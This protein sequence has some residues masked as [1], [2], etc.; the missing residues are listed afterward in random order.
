MDIDKIALGYEWSPRTVEL[1]HAD[2]EQYT[3]GGEQ[4]LKNDG[5]QIIMGG[6]SHPDATWRLWNTAG[7]DLGIRSP[8]LAGMTNMYIISDSELNSNALVDDQLL[9]PEID[10]TNYVK[11]LFDFNKNFRVWYDDDAHAQNAD[12]DIRVRSAGGAFGP[13]QNLFHMDRTDLSDP[14]VDTDSDPEHFNI[15]PYADGKIIQLRFHY[16]DAQNDY[17]FAVDDVI[18][19]GMSKPVTK[20]DITGMTF[21][22]GKVQ[23]GWSAFGTGS[24]TVEYTDNLAGGVWTAVSG[25]P[26]SAT[27]W[28]GED[29]GGFTRRFYRVKSQ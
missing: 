7:P 21:V 16:S 27:T 23:L 10:C 2:F 24:Y 9:T 14:A 26:I 20:G 13:W 17:W 19:T 6:S 4:A 18:V 11:I 29:I 1:L 15:A 8:D 25:M 12:V 28:A 3:Y 5:W 22:A